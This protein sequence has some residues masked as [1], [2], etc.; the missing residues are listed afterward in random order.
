MNSIKRSA[1][2]AAAAILTATGGVAAWMNANQ[3]DLP[4]LPDAP[5]PAVRLVHAEPF[6]LEQG[7]THF[8]RAEQ[9]TVTSG[10]VLVLEVD[11]DLAYRRET[12]MKVLYVG[13]QTAEQINFGHESGRIVV[14][15]PDEAGSEGGLA[16]KRAWFGSDERLPETIDAGWIAKEHA[17]AVAAGVQPLPAAMVSSALAEGAGEATYTDRRELERHVAQLILR[18]APGPQDRDVANGLLAPEVK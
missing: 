15:V 2:V 13:E 9:P 1:I 7:Y 11:P 6:Q 18:Y 17:E 4:V 14:L 5:T 12:R 10:H 16:G 3:G 8:M